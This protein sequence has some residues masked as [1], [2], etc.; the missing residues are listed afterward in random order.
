MVKKVND[1]NL[2]NLIGKSIILKTKEI[3]SN[4]ILIEDI[5][6]NLI[7]NIKI[8]KMGKIFRK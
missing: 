1:L 7:E 4:E 6:L 3:I 8:I 5:E 2:N